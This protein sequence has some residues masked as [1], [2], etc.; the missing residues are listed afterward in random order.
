MKIKSLISAAL[1]CVLCALTFAACGPNGD[2]KTDPTKG[3]ADGNK[4]SFEFAAPALPGSKSKE[5]LGNPDRGFR[6]ETYL[7]AATGMSGGSDDGWPKDAITAF[8]EEYNYY[9]DDKPVIAQTYVYLAEYSRV[10]TLPQSALDN[11]TK[12]FDH[13]HSKGVR[14]LLRFAYKYNESILMPPADIAIGH[15]KQLKPIVEKYKNDIYAL[16]AGFVGI[17]GEWH[18][19]DTMNSRDYKRVLE[20]I[21]DMAPEDMY[22]QVRYMWVKELLDKNDPRRARVGYHDDYISSIRY[23]WSSAADDAE[24]KKEA[25]ESVSTVNDAEMQWGRDETYGYVEPLGLLQRMYLHKFST[26]SIKH[27]YKEDYER[28][29]MEDYKNRSITMADIDSAN[30]ADNK[31]GE[32]LYCDKNWFLDEN[33]KETTRSWFAYLRDYMGYYLV[34]SPA[35]A[36]ITGNKLNVKLALTNYGTAAPLTMKNPELVLM[37]AAGKIVSRAEICK[38]ADLQSGKKVDASVALDLPENYAELTLGVR[39]VNPN[40]TPAKLANDLTVTNGVNVL[41]ALK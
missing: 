27:N 24:W 32:K 19:V 15:M 20:S 14:M 17:W 34:A 25:E 16:Q 31:F 6:L 23:D 35:T 22:V 4:T 38:V 3:A 9:V 30:A 21:I 39:F 7:H 36:N 1:A 5:L 33:G 11:I 10:P 28:Y 2:G 8:D 12:F 29:D 37:D 26:L 13:I 41:G 18:T 40:E